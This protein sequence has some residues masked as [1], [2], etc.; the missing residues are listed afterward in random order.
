MSKLKGLVCI[1]TGGSSGLG[2]GAVENFAKQGAKVVICDL[3]SSK[4]NEVASRL[5]SSGNVLFAPTDVQSED[6]INAAIK[7][8]RQKFG[9]LNVLV[10]CAGIGIAFRTYNINKNRTHQLTD[11]QKVINVNLVGTFNAIRLAAAA[12]AE[13]QPSKSNFS[14]ISDTIL[15]Q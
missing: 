9:S 10:N 5:S 13:N 3:P 2:L 12:F 11:F 15:F 14:P 6:D 4:G 1:V 8:A 7:L